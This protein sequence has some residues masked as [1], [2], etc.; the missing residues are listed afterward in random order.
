MTFQYVSPVDIMNG[1]YLNVSHEGCVLSE[2]NNFICYMMG[3]PPDF[4][5]SDLYVAC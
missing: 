1:R 5:I 4:T 3:D 2:M